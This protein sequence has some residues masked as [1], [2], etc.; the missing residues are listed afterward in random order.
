MASQR[1]YV[2]VPRALSFLASI[3]AVIFMATSNQNTICAIDF[4]FKFRRS[5]VF[6]YFLVGNAIAVVYGF[7]TL[8]GSRKFL[9]SR[10]I[11][12]FDVFVT[13]LLASSSSGVL[14]IALLR[15]KEDYH[16]QAAIGTGFAAVS[17][18]FFSILYTIPHSKAINCC[19]G[20]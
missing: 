10:F 6:R 16:V 17:L 8:V 15:K 5:F 20:N 4:E 14:A 18:Y 2:L 1:L 11:V 13:L 7:L 19:C 3:V 9:L 12:V